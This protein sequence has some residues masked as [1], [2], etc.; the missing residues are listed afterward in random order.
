[1]ISFISRGRFMPIISNSFYLEQIFVDDSREESSVAGEALTIDEQLTREWAREIDYPM[2][3]DH[4]LARVMGYYLVE[5]RDPWWAKEAYIQFLK[6][7]LL[8]VSE[9]AGDDGDVVR[10]LKSQAKEARFSEIVRQLDYPRFPEAERDPLR[11]LARLPLPIYVTTSYY[12]FLER[13]LFAEGKRP[14][15]HVCLWKGDIDVKPEHALDPQNDRFTPAEPVVYHLYGLEDYPATLVLSEDD[16]L[17]FLKQIASDNNTQKPI[18]PLRLRQAFAESSPLLLG[19][20]QQDL[21]FRVLFNLLSN[22]RRADFS[23]PGIAVQIAPT[24]DG[25]DRTRQYLK[26][27]FDYYQFGIEWTSAE[28]FVQQLWEA[29]KRSSLQ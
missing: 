24:N 5:E 7:F 6:G 18:I 1:M 11:L 17:T 26:H 8:S 22:F 29:Y 20:R 15:T 28:N 9:S 23:R 21:D 27:Y 19:Y 25:S 4:N 3:D 13:A 2:A 12:D 10:Q 14:R 16:Y